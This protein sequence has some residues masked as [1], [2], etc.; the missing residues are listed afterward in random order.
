MTERAPFF[1]GRFR[2]A[3]YG[4]VF[5]CVSENFVGRQVPRVLTFILQQD[6]RCSEVCYG[7]LVF[8]FQAAYDAGML[9]LDDSSIALIPA[10][11]TSSPW[12]CIMG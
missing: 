9:F 11:V 1:P 6:L 10:L 5:L 7:N 12:T 8:A 2:W 3:I 4:V